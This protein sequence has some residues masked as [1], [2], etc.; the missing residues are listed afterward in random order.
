MAETNSSIFHRFCLYVDKTIFSKRNI[1]GTIAFIVD[2][3]FVDDFCKQEETTEDILLRDVRCRL[4]SPDRNHLHIKGILAIQL[5]A[6][7]KR[8]DSGGITE[9]NYRDRLS[10]VLNWDI[11]DLQ[12]W[13]IEHQEH[14]W[15]SLYKWCDD[16]GF[17]IAKCRPKTGAGRYVQYP[18][19]QA[20]RVFTLKDLKYISYHF[21]ENNLQPGEDIQERD[22]WKILKKNSLASY[23]H[24]PHGKRLI[25]NPEY[26]QDAYIQIFN[27]FLRWDGSYLNYKINKS[28]SIESEKTFLYL[29]G[30]YDHI[31]I[32]DINFKRVKRL[33]LKDIDIHD[34]QADYRFK[35][36]NLILFRRYENYNDYWEETRYLEDQ[37]DGIAI[38]FKSSAI[39][40][41]WDSASR[42]FSHLKPV[43]KTDELTVYR[44]KYSLSLSSLY[45][46]RRFFVLVG[47]L[48]IGR[49]Q[50]IVDVPP[51]LK[52]ERESIFWIDGELPNKRIT[53]GNLTLDF[54]DVGHHEIKFPN[55]KALEFEIVNCNVGAS[56]WDDQFNKWSLQRNA[57]LWITTP[58][59]D[60]GIV[61]LDFSC[62]PMR[63]RTKTIDDTPILTRWAQ[64][65]LLG[66]QIIEKAPH[67]KLIT[68]N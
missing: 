6:A 37:E 60:T 68:E 54:L 62:I 43:Y 8:E 64:A 23:V 31:D 24:T 52:M 51:T 50:Y 53:N 41:T 7:S 29:T 63:V 67:I 28:G 26:I 57:N 47:G 2:Q 35:R 59:I 46:E 11:N 22:F 61:G 14:F 20:N 32:K 21:V 45:T 12:N 25:Q 33:E 5:F 48:K 49:M 40:S 36:P 9:A 15:N 56:Q 42:L 1:G 3:A 18:V 19:Q 10:Q 66:Q 4:Y 16:N 34:I 27:H 39:Y 44:F 38:V 13:M 30:D 65:H 17:H 58:S 55:H